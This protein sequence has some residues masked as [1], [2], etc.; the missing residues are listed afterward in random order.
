MNK[1]PT[2]LL[3]LIFSYLTHDIVLPILPL[4]NSRW[5]E[6]HRNINVLDLDHLLSKSKRYSLKKVVSYFP[7]ASS[8]ALRTKNINFDSLEEFK[9]CPTIKVLEIDSNYLLPS[10]RNCPKLQKLIILP[11]DDSQANASAPTRNLITILNCLPTLNFLEIHCPCIWQRNAEFRSYRSLTKLRLFNLNT[12]GFD[13]FWDWLSIGQRFS[14]LAELF[15]DLD[16]WT[17]PENAVKAISTGCPYLSI[18]KLRHATI[19]FYAI[20]D[21]S[22]NLK[23]LT[24]LSFG[25]CKIL[26]ST[27]KWTNILYSILT[28]IPFLECLHFNGCDLT[29]AENII[30]LETFTFSDDLEFPY[31]KSFKAFDLNH[32]KIKLH[33]LMNLL[34]AFPNLKSLR[35]DVS[36][37]FVLPTE[38]KGL[39]T[40]ELRYSKYLFETSYTQN[41]NQELSEFRN[42]KS[43]TL[44]SPCGFPKEIVTSNAVNLV[45]ICFNYSISGLL[46]ALED[47]CQT[48]AFPHL[49]TLEIRSIS[50]DECVRFLNL[51][52]QSYLPKL[53]KLDIDALGRED[54]LLDNN[55]LS[56]L[57]ERSPYLQYFHLTGFALPN[58]FF[59]G[60]KNEW[61]ELRKMTIRVSDSILVTDEWI[62]TQFVPFLETH[63]LLR[64]LLLSVKQVNILNFEF[65]MTDAT[66]PLA[67]SQ[68][69]S[70]M[71]PRRNEQLQNSIFSIFSNH[72][73]SKYWWIQECI[74]WKS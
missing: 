54:Y 33:D 17:L 2:E 9:G 48:L 8:L 24:H 21:I 31:M 7:C 20:G 3:T 25:H 61:L 50:H 38:L 53:R 63:R 19:P 58:D 68:E 52:L 11:S 29:I 56:V 69:K 14:N 4:V 43:L 15:L 23:S 18:F 62:E 57:K 36:G 6:A 49:Q 32:D 44:W 74:L 12:G 26:S 47:V 46:V 71:Y 42:L 35:C 1:L 30:L 10:L 40:I 45:H 13:D 28:L 55:V 39:D 5:K 51:F 16:S 27:L 37:A 60:L 67:L 22:R 34:K 64:T 65:M 73:T 70:R 72:I 41:H 59:S 66:A